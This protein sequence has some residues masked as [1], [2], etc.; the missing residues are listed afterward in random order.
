MIAINYNI[1][2]ENKSSI[3][4]PQEPKPL[5]TPVPLVSYRLYD[6]AKD[7]FADVLTETVDDLTDEPSENYIYYDHDYHTQTSDHEVIRTKRDYISDAISTGI[8]L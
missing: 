4:E 2:N 6:I 5:Y 1:S 8:E 3:S 7:D